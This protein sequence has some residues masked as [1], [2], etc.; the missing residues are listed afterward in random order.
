MKIIIA[1]DSFKGSLSAKEVCDNIELGIRKF[2]NEIDIIKIPMADGGE[3]TLEALVE[4]TGGRLINTTVRDP[5]F[6]NIE[7]QYG[8]LGNN[9]TAIIEMSK[10]SGLTLLNE[11]ERNP[12]LTTTYGTGE[13]ILHALNSGCRDFIVALGGSATNDG[14]IGLLGA[15]G[16]KFLDENGNPVELTGGGLN[17]I[18]SIDKTAMDSRIMESTFTIA[19]DVENV[20]T[21]VEGAAFVYGPQKGANLLMVH[22]LDRGLRNFAYRINEYLGIDVEHIQGSGAAGGV[23]AGIIGLFG[24]KIKRGIDIVI[25]YTE[26]EEKLRDADLL[27]TGEGRMDYQTKFGKTPFGVAKL[28]AKYDIPVVAVCGWLGDRY[29]ELYNYGF[30]SIFSITDKPMTLEECIKETPELLQ[31]ISSSIVRL[32]NNRGE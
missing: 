31:K 6:K 23:A 17:N 27:I 15:L 3:G 28:A 21:G 18:R 22:A 16:V 11:E 32:I 4:A 30:T 26:L 5:L 10:S 25:E 7:A 20:L 9:K 14:G 12:L 1:P 2:Y 29:E 24:G 8:I 19:T 13:L